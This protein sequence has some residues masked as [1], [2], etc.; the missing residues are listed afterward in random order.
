M[1][2]FR[3]TILKKIGGNIRRER[4]KKSIP[5]IELA[6]ACKISRSHFSRIEHGQVRINVE[7]LYKITKTL[8]ISADQILPF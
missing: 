5:Q 7:Q 3:N 1:V 4:L 6:E 2:N 8:D